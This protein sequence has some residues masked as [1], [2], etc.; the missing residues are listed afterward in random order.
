MVEIIFGLEILGYFW[1]KWLIWNKSIH[2]HLQVEAN[3]KKLHKKT[4]A[5]F[6]IYG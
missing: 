3:S 6:S 4:D 5:I 1:D 2:Y